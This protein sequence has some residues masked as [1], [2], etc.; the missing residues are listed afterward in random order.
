MMS[1][2]FRLVAA[3]IV[4]ACLFIG[5]ASAQLYTES[6]TL[7]GGQTKTSQ[8]YYMPGM[9]KFVQDDG[10]TVIIRFDREYWIG[11]DTRKKEYWQMTFAELEAKM[12]TFGVQMDAAVQQMQKQ[13]ESMPPDQ[14][15]K[16]EQMMDSQLGAK[17]ASGPLAVKKGGPAR[18]IAGLASTR[19]SVTESGKE[20]LVLWTARDVPEFTAM[21]KDYEK[22]ARSMAAMR[23]SSGAD[24]QTRAWAEAM[25]TIDGFPMETESAGSKTTVTKFERKRTPASD[26]EAPAG[27]KKVPPPF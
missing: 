12:K 8:S 23:P 20:I 16:I 18:T 22:F 21:R 19:L 7:A 9:F 2:F 3:C 26:F 27:Y 6:T 17:G 4:S 13:L 25:K 1:L 11:A 24:T 5:S 15:Q 14:R 10:S